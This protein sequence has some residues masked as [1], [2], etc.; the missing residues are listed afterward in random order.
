MKKMIAFNT[1][2]NTLIETVKNEI[3]KGMERT[4]AIEKT[5]TY[6]NIGKNIH[7][8][9]LK[10]SERADYGEAL[11]KLLSSELNIGSSILYRT[12]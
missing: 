10:Y 12:V 1:E 8:H 7:Q 6:W 11:F 5:T 9:L 3:V 4:I 2:I